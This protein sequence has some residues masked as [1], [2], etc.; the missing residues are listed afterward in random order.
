MTHTYP[1][2]ITPAGM[3]AYVSI[4]AIHPLAGF[5]SLHPFSHEILY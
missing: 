4:K 3:P 2:V 5:H 1:P